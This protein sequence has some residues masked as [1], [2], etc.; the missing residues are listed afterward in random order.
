MLPSASFRNMLKDQ[1]NSF[2][3]GKHEKAVKSLNLKNLLE[4]LKDKNSTSLKVTYL[5]LANNL[6][7]LIF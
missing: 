5:D 4:S 7:S 2:L 1:S 3:S 6:S